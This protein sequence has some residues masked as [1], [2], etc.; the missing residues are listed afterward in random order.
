MLL[1]L[2]LITVQAVICKLHMGWASSVGVTCLDMNQHGSDYGAGMLLPH[3]NACDAPVEI[4]SGTLTM[5]RLW[6]NMY[7]LEQ[8]DY[9]V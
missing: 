1:S 7:L 8:S 2:L 4:L 5:G 9:V 3:S 6:E